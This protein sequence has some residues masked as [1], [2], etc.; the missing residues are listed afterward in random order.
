MKRDAEMIL[1]L[2]ENRGQY[3]PR[4]F[5]RE[6]K[7]ECISGVDAAD[8]DY[9]ARG[10]GGCLDDDDTLAD[11]ETVRGEHYWDVWAD[12]CDHATVTSTD[13]TEYMVYQDGDCWLIEKGADYDDRT[14]SWFVSDDSD[15]LWYSTSSGRIEL[16]MTLDQAQS[17]HHQGS[18]DADVRALSEQEDIAKQLA[19][20]DPD[21]LRGELK[22]YG[23]WDAAELADHDQNLQRLLWLAAGDIV[24]QSRQ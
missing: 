1:L 18:C 11:G 20:I 9:L 7:R 17:A 15:Q 2:S 8:L 23:A 22:E 16:S 14:D 21:V 4:D 13:G 6:V 5:A 10:P 3:I 12:V 19:D 24:E